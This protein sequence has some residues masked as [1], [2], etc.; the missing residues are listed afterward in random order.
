MEENN[1]QA[2]T[3][4]LDLDKIVDELLAQGKG[5]SEEER[6]KYC[7]DIGEHPLFADSYDVHSKTQ[8]CFNVFI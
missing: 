8:Y 1:P 5:W 7:D 3:V 2:Q 6:Q 4:N